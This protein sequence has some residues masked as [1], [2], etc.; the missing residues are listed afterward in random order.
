MSGARILNDAQLDEMCTLRERGWGLDRIAAH[1]TEAGTAI[2]PQAINWQCMRLGAD[3][4]PRLRGTHSQAESPYLRGKHPVRPF[5]GEEDALL[6]VLEMQGFR[7]SEIARRMGR[8]PNS[9]KGRLY[10]LARQDARQ[11]E[12]AA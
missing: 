1:F 2:S 4:P 5:T 6:R 12:R 3:V 9:I 7:I 11:E 10:T 8:K